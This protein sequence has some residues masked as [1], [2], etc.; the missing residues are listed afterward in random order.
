[1]KSIIT[2]LIALAVTFTTFAQKD[3]Q[4]KATYMSKRTMDMSRFDKMPEQ[5]KKQM[6]ARFKSF[7]EKTYTLSFNKTESAFK[8][9]VQLDAPGASGPSWGKSNGQ[10]SIYKNTGEK[11]MIEDVESFSKRFLVTEKMETPKWEMG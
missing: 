6:M 8:E 9:N 2:L 11:E 7:L 3:F 1:M 5:Q 4:G 10:G